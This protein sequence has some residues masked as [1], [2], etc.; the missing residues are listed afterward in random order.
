MIILK[1][2][3]KEKIR[4]AIS[5]STLTMSHRLS[6]HSENKNSGGRNCRAKWT[7]PEAVDSLGRS[8]GE[9]CYCP[10]EHLK[11]HQIQ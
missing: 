8:Q 4:V 2:K 6:S 3:V 1:Q 7:F 10:S 11:I 9:F 5:G